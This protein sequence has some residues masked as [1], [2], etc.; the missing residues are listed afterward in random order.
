MRLVPLVRAILLLSKRP[1]LLAAGPPFFRTSDV[2]RIHVGELATAEDHVN[3]LGA[4]GMRLHPA[5][6]ILLPKSGASTFT[7]HRVIMSVDGYVSSHLAT[8]RADE[9]RATARYLFYALQLV[10]ARDVASDA[11]YPT[12]S[13]EQ[14]RSIKVAVPPISEQQ[15][16]VATLDEAFEG[17][18]T[19]TANAEKN[20][21]NARRLANIVLNLAFDSADDREIR[22]LGTVVDFQGGA[23]PPKSSFVRT[24]TDDY[25]R[26]LQIRDFKSDNYAVYVKKDRRLRF[27]NADDVMIGRYGASVGQIHRGKAGAYNVALI[28]ATPH[29]PVTKDFLYYFFQS[30]VF[31]TRLANVASRSAQAGFGK[32]D[33]YPFPIQVPARDVQDTTVT[34]LRQVHAEVDELTG[35]VR[36]KLAV[37]AEFKQSLL[38][39]AFS[40]E[41]TAGNA[42]A[43]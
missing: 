21:A 36:R 1:Y 16:I 5:G 25:V 11:A 10:A 29:P 3:E 8:V 12:L 39:R 24:P 2:G 20:L 18:A 17:I 30:N 19:A 23:Q 41:L 26:L 43:A 34:R 31:Q 13:L 6:T 4:T 40:G 15:C 32:E 27:C 37:L 28:K 33:I 9:T 7:D 22:L 14:I 42:I 38:A 35:A